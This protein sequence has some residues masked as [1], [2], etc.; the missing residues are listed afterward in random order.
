MSNLPY[1]DSQGLRLL[2]QLFTNEDRIFTREAALRAAQAQKIPQSELNI[3]LSRLSKK[4][5]ILRLRRGLYTCIGILGETSKVHPF[6]VSSFLALPSAISHMSA[7]HYHG[8]T[9]QIPLS[10]TASSPKPLYM[11]KMIVEGVSYEY[12]V[13]QPKHFDFGIE[14]IWIDPHFQ[15][16]ITDKERTLIDLFA[17][18]KR[19]GGMGE[20]LGILED[21]LPSLN[22]N[23][24]V[25]YA[26]KYDEKSL[27]KRLGWALEYLGEPD[28]T[29][30][31]LLDVQMSHYC[32]L[33]PAK[34]AVGQCD[35]RWM[36]QNNLKSE[37][38]KNENN[39]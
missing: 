38:N 32:S 11:P 8:L 22:I 25:D 12:T 30:K 33:D 13:V 5:M 17:Y 29:F 31:R 27:C 37:Y 28:E 15:V 14:D 21:A 34:I 9:E 23:R 6:A 10:V 3:I 2:A 19:F 18:A 1:K 4:G 7:L 39:T 24:L 35:K 16:K 36:I 20:V 26:L